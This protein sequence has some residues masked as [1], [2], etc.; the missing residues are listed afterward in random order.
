MNSVN[1][2]WVKLWRELLAKSIWMQSSPQCCKV[3]I[4]ILLLANHEENEWEYKG[5]K[6]KCMPGQLYTSIESL[7]KHCGQGV[8]TNGARGALA[9]LVAT[10]FITDEA[11]K[12][13]RLITVVN[14]DKYQ[15]IKKKNHKE[16][17]N[18]DNNV[19][20]EQ[21]H[22]DTTKTPQLTRKKEGEEELKKIKESVTPSPEGSAAA[23]KEDPDSWWDSLEDETPK[24]WRRK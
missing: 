10:G 6:Y 5:E 24:E 19:D 22:K 18:V 7:K 2:G 4:T 12:R 16:N 15:G 23:L 9:R 21:H 8:T 1:S 20:H 13:G 3:L 11:T 14:W 17:H